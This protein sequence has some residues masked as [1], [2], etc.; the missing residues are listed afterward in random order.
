METPGPTGGNCAAPHAQR[1]H[2]PAVPK[3]SCPLG[4]AVLGLFCPSCPEQGWLQTWRG[5]NSA[6]FSAI[7]I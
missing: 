3:Q 6:H 7:A 5:M 4:S 2:R 1:G